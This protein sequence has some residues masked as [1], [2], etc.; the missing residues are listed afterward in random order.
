MKDELRKPLGEV[1]ADTESLLELVKKTKFPAL[2]AVG[3]VCAKALMD[4]G[5]TPD[6][7]VIDG[8]TKREAFNWKPKFSGKVVQVKNEPSTISDELDEAVEQVFSD[9]PAKTMIRVD[10]EEDLAV[11]PALKYCPLNSLVVYG[12]WP[13]GVVAVTANEDMKNNSTR[14][15]GEMDED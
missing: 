7:S 10:G 4:N 12:L 11:L 5:I 8:R 6:L 14:L 3:D 2:I 1:F 13:R 9:K 15:M